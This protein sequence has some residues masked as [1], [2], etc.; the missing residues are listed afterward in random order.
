[1]G[2]RRRHVILIAFGD[3]SE[4]VSEMWLARQRLVNGA[5]ILFRVWRANDQQPLRQGISLSRSRKHFHTDL[6]T[7]NLLDPRNAHPT[8]DETD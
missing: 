4:V 7:C 1:M 5:N 2:N 6:R 3:H 8:F